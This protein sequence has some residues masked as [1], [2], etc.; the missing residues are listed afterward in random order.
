MEM[1]YSSGYRTANKLETMVFV[2]WTPYPNHGIDA[3]I[4]VLSS[5][6][7]TSLQKLGI[8]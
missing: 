4:P 5:T 2:F 3:F 7:H 8:T 1:A 6:S